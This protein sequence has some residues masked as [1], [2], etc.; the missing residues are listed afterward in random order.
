MIGPRIEHVPVVGGDLAVRVW[1]PGDPD[2][3][4]VL[5]AHGITSNGLAWA[6]VADLLDDVRFVAPDLRG[7]ALSAA[8]P[9]PYGLRA[10]AA[11]LAAV[12]D[13]L[14][15]RRAVVA[16]HSMG[17]FVALLVAADH[18]VGTPA[19]VLVDGGI[20]LQ[21]PDGV[22]L[23]Q[24]G[25][26]VLG[27][28]L[29]RLSMTFPDRAAYRAY[30]QRHPA[31]QDWS[32]LLD[33]YVDADLR[34]DVPDL[35]PSSVR[36]AVDADTRDEF[37]PDW[38]LDAARSLRMPVV[39]LR[40]PRGLQNAEPLYPPGR[41]EQF[42]ADIPQLRVVEVDDVNHYTIVLGGGAATVAAELRALLTP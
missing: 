14:G 4:A 9:A 21:L 38:Y 33:A 42:R 5:A 8:L 29:E 12:R 30:W 18:P 36:E 15:L 24:F 22:T 17:A 2:A 3:P 34:G 31:L 37:G 25:A 26:A 23:D 20:P 35:R 27:P 28:A 32:A 10:H 16:G 13:A 40:A 7:R 19:L 6:A 41:I 39:A 1:G 11:D